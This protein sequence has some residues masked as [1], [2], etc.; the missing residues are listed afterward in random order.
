ML[1]HATLA[2][3]FD[4]PPVSR[5]GDAETGIRTNTFDTTQD[6]DGVIYVASTQLLSFDGDR[7]Q[8]FP[9]PG[10]YAI[11][12]LSFGPDGR[13][14]VAA[15]GELGW[16]ARAPDRTWV[17][18]SLRPQLP[19][20]ERDVGDVWTV[21][22]DA[23]GV[24][25]VTNNRILRWDGTAFTVWAQ[26]TASK[27]FST[28]TPGGVLV[29]HL[30]TGLYEVDA[31]GVRLLVAAG[32]LGEA[33]IP[34]I[35]RRGALWTFGTSH[36]FFTYDGQVRR[37]FAPGLTAFLEANRLSHALRLPDGRIAVGTV[38]G[39]IAFVRPSGEID[40]FLGAREGL[41]SSEIRSFFTGRDG[42]LWATTPSHVLRID[43]TARSVVFNER[44][45]LPAETIR[46]FATLNGRLVLA[47]ES[48]L[49]RLAEN[50]NR[51]E[52]LPNFTG[53]WKDIR[54][55]D[56]GVIVSGFK[57]SQIWDGTQATRLHV[58]N[59]DV[60]ATAPSRHRSGEWLL[61]DGDT[62]V[63]AAP[64]AS[65]R[66]LLRDL[67]DFA[68]SIAEDKQ[69]RVWLGSFA[70][71]IFTGDPAAGHDVVNASTS[72]TG[73]PL[74][75]GQ[76]YVRAGADG[77]IIA[78]ANTGAWYRP[79]DAS[80][81]HP[82]AQYPIGSVGDVS[83]ID[84]DGAFWVVQ[85]G[86]AQSAARVG[87]ILTDGARAW[88]QTHVVNELAEIG[89]PRGVFVQALPGDQRL[90]W[91]GGTRALLRHAFHARVPLAPAPMPRPPL[92]RAFVRQA[93]KAERKL[94][95]GP[96]PYLTEAIEIELAA[97]DY[98]RRPLLRLETRIDG[99]NQ[100]WAPVGADARVMLNGVRDGTYV[101]RAR[102]VAETGLASEE[103]SF[104][105]EVL[106]PWWRTA[107]AYL[108]GLLAFAATTF[109][110]HRRRVRVLS[111]QNA[112]LE[113]RVRQRTEELE[114]ASAAKTEF[115]AN[116]SHD[117]RNP[118]NGIVGLAI[119]LEDTPLTPKQLELVT[120]LRECSTYLSSLVDDVLDFAS[121]ESGKI[122]LRPGPFAP[123][124]LLRS[125]AET[126]KSD[127]IASGASLCLEPDA[128]LP[129]HVLGDAGRIQQILVN[130]VSNALKYAGGQIVLSARVPAQAP[131]EIEFSV[132]DAGPGIS[133][134]D[135]AALFTKF[136]RLKSNPRLASIPGT[137]LGLA[138]CRLLAD[139]M[140][141][142]V[143]LESSPGHG[144]RFFL[145]LPLAV[146]NTPVEAPAATLP[147]AT[148]LL[149][150][151]T[152]YNA[153]AAA[154]V[155][156]RLGLECERART[157][158]EALRLFGEKRFNVVLLDR[159][160]PDMDGNDV[161]RRIREMESD[162]EQAVLLAVTAYC[163]AEDR[164]L[165]LE[166]GMDAFVGKPLTPEKLRRVL[167]ETGRR[168]LT[169]PP[170]D[171]PP[172][173]AESGLDFSLLTYLSDGSRAKLDA[174]IQ[175]FIASI[176][177]VERQLSAAAAALDFVQLRTTAHRLLGEARLVGS[178]A[179]AEATTRLESA[180]RS[181]DGSECT[182]WLQRV[183]VEIHAVTAAMHHHRSAG[184]RA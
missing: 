34:W 94:I 148:V 70:R 12:R 173:A 104:A 180:A 97:A 149:V 3:A 86:S 159:N 153:W 44:S 8:A 26:P 13:L 119:A 75:T 78:V 113:K 102:V 152:D 73:L 162:G 83:E 133:A 157:G 43:V 35:E 30:E 109:F 62:I 90:L 50:E 160:L 93:G 107:P 4:L 29:H 79:A 103:T 27:L 59:A 172:A 154:A 147:N 91:I 130:F 85:E 18:H 38:R 24:T 100:A 142:S 69:G 129:E 128:H 2:A 64:G 132:T 40:G 158:A 99:L 117:I 166:A 175:R 167:N 11:R 65:P 96:L 165:C 52:P 31:A 37:P 95:A 134:A 33:G 61:A 122:D 41:P 16:Y 77:S 143:G 137:G 181:R 5:Y 111:E 92:L 19:P 115:V 58:T 145:R 76:T 32:I 131:D 155:L 138:S 45:G 17:F 178:T 105:I 71:G 176:E 116:M 169:T 66:L 81:F 87:R 47:A 48:G 164:A 67:P 184:P 68:S 171:I 101:V 120:T 183:G 49:F 121:I 1:V 25:F 114:A 6:R 179:L 168:L 124:E 14:W 42:E 125:I 140:G 163:T 170:V 82:V 46:K 141:G 63:A 106:P 55:T 28:R 98:V 7:W 112:I 156:S 150:E 177:D 57:G 39:G 56:R 118:L 15:I 136:T 36:G 146:S 108:G 60:L 89:V 182:A 80:T 151:D 127:A 74:L 88:W 139:I 174:H 54:G 10:A 144:S 53:R 22:A 23:A 72:A 110:F 135:Q 161:A 20:G 9:L 126:M 21:A 84:P 51:F 123:P